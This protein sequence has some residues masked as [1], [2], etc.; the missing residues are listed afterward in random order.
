MIP[1]KVVR[2]AEQQDKIARLYA[3]AERLH[4]KIGAK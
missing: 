3:L 4:V 2:T 1:K